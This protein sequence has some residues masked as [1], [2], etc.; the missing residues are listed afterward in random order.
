MTR[1]HRTLAVLAAA[2]AVAAVFLDLGS[3][4][5]ATSRS[6]AVDPVDYISAPDLAARV[7]GQDAALLVIDLRSRQ[8]FD[9]LHVAGATNLALDDLGRQP[10]RRDAR[11]VLYA[12]DDARAVKG[13]R[14]L[15][16][17]GYQNVAILRDGIYEWIARVLEP[18]LATDATPTERAE[19]D[20]AVP[21]SRFFGGLPR[22]DTSR[23]E[24]ARGYWT[25]APLSRSDSRELLAR[26][27]IA[28]IRRR[29]C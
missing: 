8:D 24:V 9:Q 25:G 26:Q 21:L 20:R 17:R 12:N 28:G 2:L 7:I 11:I 5:S 13:L 19:F 14:L 3:S 10:F 22:S 4:A 18:R 29:G 23:A 15:H 1:M 16:T 27:A 6:A